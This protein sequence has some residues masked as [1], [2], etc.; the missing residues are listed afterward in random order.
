MS[1]L[2]TLVPCSA[3]ELG[4]LVGMLLAT[5]GWQ[6]LKKLEL[7]EQPRPEL[8]FRIS[9]GL[10]R[11]FVTA[12]LGRSVPDIAVPLL[13]GRTAALRSPAQVIERIGRAHGPALAR[14]AND[15]ARLEAA[16][17]ELAAKVGTELGQ[18]IDAVFAAVDRT[19]R[20]SPGL[21]SFVQDNAPY[22]LR[23][24]LGHLG[25]QSCHGARW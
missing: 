22:N 23:A 7:A 9:L 16:F 17:E 13:P 15:R 19:Q 20:T 21:L 3:D 10:L 4:W 1:D 2:E 12:R 6:Y 11:P 5:D 14:L 24:E 8:R 18:A 25:M